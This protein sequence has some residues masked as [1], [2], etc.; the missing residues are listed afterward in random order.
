M[1]AESFYFWGAV[2]FR[3]VTFKI[4]FDMVMSVLSAWRK[5]KTMEN[6]H[7]QFEKIMK[8]LNDE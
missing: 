8:D 3:V 1:E 2:C 6:M 5:T 4:F 7:L